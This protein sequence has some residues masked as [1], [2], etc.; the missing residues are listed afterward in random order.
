MGKIRNAHISVRKSEGKEQSGK[1]RQRWENNIKRNIKNIWH[2][3][4][5]W[6]QLTQNRINGVLL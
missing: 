4:M 2:D 1:P 6:P 5:N 3:S